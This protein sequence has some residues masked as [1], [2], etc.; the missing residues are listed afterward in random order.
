MKEFWKMALASLTALIIFGFLSVFI[1][2]SVIAGLFLSTETGPA[3]PEKAVLTI[4]MSQVTL[5]EQ[6]HEVELMNMLS[7][8]TPP[9]PLGILDIVSAINSAAFDPAVKY[10]LLKPDMTTG[11][12][13]Q[14]EEIR[15]ALEEFR[16]SG[17]A[18]V[19]YIENP[20]NAG[21]YL[22]SVSDKI[23]MTSHEGGMNTFNGLSTQMLFLKDALDRL[24]INVQLIR[25]GKFKSAGEMF[26]R[27]SSSK[28][29]M[30]QNQE[31]IDSMWDS[32]SRQIAES[33]S[34]TPEKLDGLLNSLE[35]N[36]PED[37]L[38][39]GLVDELLTQDQLQSKL[40]VLFMTDKFSN[41]K[42]ISL[43]DYCQLTVTGNPQAS[44]K[45]AVIYVEGNIVDGNGEEEVAGDRF[46]SIIRKVRN[47]KSVKAV[48]LRVNSP[49]GSVLASEK[50]KTEID[51]LKEN[52][53]V[54]AS[55]GDY[56]AS[57]GYWIS[58]GCDYIYTDATTLTGSIGV[59]SLIP[60]FSGTLGKK[61]HVNLTSVNSNPH[62]DMY[63]M[64]R[65]LTEEET[66]YMQ[67]SVE[68][69]YDRFTHIVA[70]GREMS[71]EEVDAIGQGRVWTGVQA[72]ELG[73]ADCI[74][75]LNQAILHAALLIDGNNGLEN[76]QIAEYPKPKTLED[77]I[78]KALTGEDTMEISEPLMTVWKGFRGWTA[79]Q[80]G[81]VYARLPYAIEIR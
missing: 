24:G 66:A 40:A 57:G 34:M 18:V 81:K 79:D 56:A 20:T 10:I 23:Y 55:F 16:M 35:L 30:H 13:A 36:F 5:S 2:I 76:I 25:H 26:V 1:M 50:I 3:M 70:E 43:Q 7:V 47:D 41:V 37:F 54:I 72:V 58:A 49:G 14:I 19:S 17:K 59:F 15:A 78:M 21:Y 46:A 65:A 4:D 52:V 32:W 33:R 8:E 9:Q 6:T 42:T 61:L 62:A 22:A 64:T 69:I 31:T 45:V 11:G 29:N 77:I 12:P 80:S 28:E 74:G 71:I 44:S 27:T 73:L 53:P 68:R 60:D 48:V 39:H 67:E 51:L 75:S 38:E 63:N